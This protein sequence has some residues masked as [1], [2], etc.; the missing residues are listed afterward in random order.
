MD[1]AG[2]WFWFDNTRLVMYIERVTLRL[3]RVYLWNGL[4]NIVVCCSDYSVWSK[5][6]MWWISHL[7]SC[8]GQILIHLAKVIALLSKYVALLSKARQTLRIEPNFNPDRSPPT[9]DA[10]QTV[11]SFLNITGEVFY[12]KRLDWLCRTDTIRSVSSSSGS[13]CFFLLFVHSSSCTKE[14]SLSLFLRTSPCLNSLYRN[15]Q[16]TKPTKGSVLTFSVSST[17][18]SVSVS[19]AER[20]I[21]MCNVNEHYATHTVSAQRSRFCFSLKLNI[22]FHKCVFFC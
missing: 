8:I 6:T 10:Q 20:L 1:G 9:K 13:R 19:S 14:R 3:L 21:I 7:L 15:C 11:V 18:R 12:L 4:P 5:V 2:F 17:S 16:W 22:L